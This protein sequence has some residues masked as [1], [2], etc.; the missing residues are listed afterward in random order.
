MSD[1]RG[2]GYSYSLSLCLFSCL[3]DIPPRC[4]WLPPAA[5]VG[6]HVKN[7]IGLVS[8]V[9]GERHSVPLFWEVGISR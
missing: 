1:Q 3:F 7:L 8:Q 9:W 6:N 5:A 2:G 4:A